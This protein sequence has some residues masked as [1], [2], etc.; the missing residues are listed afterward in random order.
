M[1]KPFFAPLRA[2]LLC[3]PVVC[4]AQATPAENTL[5]DGVPGV[6]TTQV[7]Q[8]RIEKLS[9]ELKA[10][11]AYLTVGADG[12][13]GCACGGG[14]TVPNVRGPGPRPPLDAQHLVQGLQALQLVLNNEKA[15]LVTTIYS[16]Q[17]PKAGAAVAMPN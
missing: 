15:G 13:L 17:A 4:A 16:T 8:A 7:M 6:M 14:P 11:G 10:I 2:A 9:L 5:P 12:R 1:F 3:A